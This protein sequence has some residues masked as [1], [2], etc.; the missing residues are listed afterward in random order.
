[1]SA[2]AVAT[3]ASSMWTH[4]QT[5]SPSP[6][7]GISC[8]RAWSAEAPSG[9]TRCP[10][11]RR[12]RTAGATPSM[13]RRPAP[14]TPTRRRAGVEGNA[15]AGVHRHPLGLVRQPRAGPEEEAA[16]LLDVPPDTAGRAARRRLPP[17]SILSHRSI[18]CG[19]RHVGRAFRQGRQLV[20]DDLG[21]D[22]RQ[23]PLDGSAA[24]VRPPR[25][26]RAE[27][28]RPCVPAWNGSSP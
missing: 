14:A 22:L 2:S 28:V 27:S 4:D 13:P 8:R 25:D 5:P 26:V 18:V 24:S 21:P 19:R 15:R 6:M 17:P 12:T 3:A 16:G 1:M 9:C 23:C 10:A 7:I 20:D 11:R